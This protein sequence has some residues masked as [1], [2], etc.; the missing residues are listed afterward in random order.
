MSKSNELVL[1]KWKTSEMME[2]FYGFTAAVML[3]SIAVHYLAGVWLLPLTSLMVA[4]VHFL[5]SLA[6]LYWLF[7]QPARRP[8]AITGNELILRYGTIASAVIPLS[9]IVSMEA[10]DMVSSES[11][12]ATIKKPGRCL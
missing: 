7:V 11:F 9:N 10:T 2:F 8:H 1:S 12:G 4:V 6:L 5:L 3:E